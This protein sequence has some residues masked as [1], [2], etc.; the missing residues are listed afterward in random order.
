ML[1]IK[2][3]YSQN[4]YIKIYIRDS[5]HKNF[6]RARRP[7]VDKWFSDNLLND[8]WCLIDETAAKAVGAVGAAGADHAKQA[9]Q[10][11]Q[12]DRAKRIKFQATPTQC[13]SS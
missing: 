11:G 8:S 3:E 9:N 2:S 5:I 1:P 12:A 10:A 6:V 4:I 13:S 7:V